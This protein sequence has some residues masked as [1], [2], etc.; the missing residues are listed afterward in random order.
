M[1][2][3]GNFCCKFYV[4]CADR[5]F[6]L[7]N[8]QGL[9]V[10]AEQIEDDGALIYT[11]IAHIPSILRLAYQLDPQTKLQFSPDFRITIPDG[12]EHTYY[13]GRVESTPIVDAAE[14]ELKHL[15]SLPSE[16]F[17]LSEI[18]QL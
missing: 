16:L 15:S 4:L 17:T 12:I 18:G 10:M 8:A 13:I 3:C 9:G 14:T 2:G 5:K 1:N 7:L 6:R 11:R